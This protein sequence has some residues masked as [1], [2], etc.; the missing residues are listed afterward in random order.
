MHK[1]V[2]IKGPSKPSVL[3]VF[4][5]AQR[6]AQFKPSTHLVCIAENQDGLFSPSFI[7]FTKDVFACKRTDRVDA[8]SL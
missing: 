2:V 7:C 8:S 4:E 5:F 6:T 3:S 1:C